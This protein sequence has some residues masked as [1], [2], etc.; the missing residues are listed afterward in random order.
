MNIARKCSSLPTLD[1]R[2]A[3]EI[4]GYEKSELGLW[5]DD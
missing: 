5:G 2:T 1:Q 3:S 4:L